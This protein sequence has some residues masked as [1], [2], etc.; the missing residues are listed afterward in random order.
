M[1]AAALKFSCA[2]A[3]CGLINLIIILHDIV[4]HVTDSI[5]AINNYYNGYMCMWNSECIKLIE[6][7]AIIIK[8]CAHFMMNTTIGGSVQ[9]KIDDSKTGLA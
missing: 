3:E 6:F 4:A 8:F 5:I 2:S 9:D 7:E 1:Y